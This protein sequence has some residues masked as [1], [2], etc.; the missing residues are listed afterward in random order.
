MAGTQSER[1]DAL[2]STVEEIKAAVSELDSWSDDV[3]SRL[4]TH[5]RAIDTPQNNSDNARVA[6]LEEALTFLLDDR[7]G[8]NVRPAHFH[9]STRIPDPDDLDAVRERQQADAAATA[10]E[11]AQEQS[12]VDQLQAELAELRA[13]L[14]RKG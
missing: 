10:D 6:A 11:S 13:E 14:Q 7:Y 3:Q 1:L 4:D 2:E 12:R 5:T 9:E 8:K